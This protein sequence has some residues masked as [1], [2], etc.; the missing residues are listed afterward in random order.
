MISS[1]S[2]SCKYRVTRTVSSPR[3]QLSVRLCCHRRHGLSEYRARRTP[4]SL[5]CAPSGAAGIDKFR[6][7]VTRECRLHRIQRVGEHPSPTRMYPSYLQNFGSALTL[8]N[9]AGNGSE[10]PELLKVSMSSPRVCVHAACGS[11]SQPKTRQLSAAA[12]D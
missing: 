8:T 7:T 9:S 2:R 3:S 12:M 11:T 6:F 5:V 1:S 4:C 10:S